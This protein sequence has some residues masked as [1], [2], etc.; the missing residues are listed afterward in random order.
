MLRIETPEETARKAALAETERDAWELYRRAS[1]DCAPSAVLWAL[2]NAW[3]AAYKARS[4]GA[5]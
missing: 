3:A 2:Q 4:G 5:K 1:R